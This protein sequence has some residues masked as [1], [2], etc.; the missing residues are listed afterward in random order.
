MK[1]Y[2]VQPS[3][4]LIIYFKNQDN[5]NNQ[6]NF[7]FF[8]FILTNPFP[9]W[10]WSECQINPII[11]F[12]HYSVFKILFLMLKAQLTELNIRMAPGATF[13]SKEFQ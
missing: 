11:G 4:V 13:L 6:K 5:F 9:S 3:H 12:S 2:K 10:K 8:Q 7:F 1:S